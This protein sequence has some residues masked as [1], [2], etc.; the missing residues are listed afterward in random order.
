M[1]ERLPDTLALREIKYG[2]KASPARQKKVARDF[3]GCDRAADALDLFLLAQDEDGIREV[4]AWAVKE[5]HSSLLLTLKR[6]GRGPTPADWSAA[7]EKG[8]AAGR[9]RD[10]FRCFREA[11]DEAGLARVREKLPDYDIYTPAGK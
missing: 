10:A 9:W 11:S 3:L 4:M 2:E 7:G 1:A 6:A 8:L 5:G